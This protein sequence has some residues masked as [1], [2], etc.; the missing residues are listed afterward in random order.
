MAT[1]TEIVAA[2]VLHSSAAAFSHFGV[3]LEDER[4]EKPQ[5]VVE[6]V[7]ARTPRRTADKPA[8]RVEERQMR[9]QRAVVAKA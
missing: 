9:P 3:T 2:V 8:E 7:V 5:P 1:L 4:I 6:R